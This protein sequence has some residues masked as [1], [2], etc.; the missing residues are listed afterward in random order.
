MA[1][2][3]IQASDTLLLSVG[4]ESMWHLGID[5]TLRQ[6]LF[7][8][9]S[10]SDIWIGNLSGL[11]RDT[12]V[13]PVRFAGL[14]FWF[15]FVSPHAETDHD[16][17]VLELMMNNVDAD[18]IPDKASRLVKFW[19]AD[20]EYGIFKPEGWKLPRPRQIFQFAQMIRRVMCFYLDAMPEIQQFFYFPAS[21]RL[22]RL[23]ARVFRALVAARPEGGVITLNHTG[24]CHAYQRAP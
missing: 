4:V 22:Q 13:V 11:R 14:D 18:L 10:N 19:R 7:A 9:A 21:P 2:A 15:L 8:A 24:A 12:E 17:A 6:A 5:N 1:P 3:A 16:P 23:Y 20:A